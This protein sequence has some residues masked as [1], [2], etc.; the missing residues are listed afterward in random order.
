MSYHALYIV[1]DRY[2]DIRQNIINILIK[3]LIQTFLACL[4]LMV[5]KKSDK[6]HVKQSNAF[7]AHELNPGLAQTV[8]L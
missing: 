7:V 4:W 3:F 5:L 2:K 6:L 8:K 1:T